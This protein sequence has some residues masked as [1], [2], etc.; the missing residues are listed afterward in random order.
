[1]LDTWFSSAL[2]PFATL[3]WPDDTPRLR[4]F[5]PGPRAVHGARH[6]QPLGRAHD[7][8][9]ASRSPGTEPFQDVVI[10]PT[11]LA[12][13]GRRMS[14]S[15][16]TGVDPLDLIARH[17]ADA[18][19][20]GLLKMSSTQDVRFAEGTIEEG[21]GLCNKLWNAARLILLNVDPEAEPA[22][23]RAEPVDA[24][25]LGRLADAD[26]RGDR[27]ARRATTSPRRSRRSTASSGTT[28]A[29]GTS[30]PPRRASTATTRRRG[31]TSRRRCCYVLARDAAARASRAAARDR[32]HLGGARRATACW[33]AP[34]GPTPA[35]AQRDADAERAVEAGLRL[36]RQAAPAARRD[37]S[38][39]RARRST[40]A[41]LAAAAA[42]PRSSSRSGASTHGA[43][44]AAASGALVDAITVGDAP[45]T[46]LAPGGAE[47]AAAALRAASSRSAEAEVERAR[48]KLAD[49]RFVERAPAHLVEAERDKA[50]ALRARGGRAA[51]APR[52][53]RRVTAHGYLE[54]LAAFGMKL[55]LERITRAARRSSSDPQE[56]LDAIHVVGTNGKSSTVRFAAAALTASGLRTGAYL[57]PHVIGWDERVQIDGRPIG[58]GA[59]AVAL[60]RVQEAAR[61]V[62][63]EHGEGPTQFEALTAAAFLV[64][65]EA[66]VEA[67]VVE[68]GLGG[69]HDAT[70]V[71]N[72][73]VVGLTNVGLDHQRVLGDTREEILAEKLAVLEPRRR[74][75]RR[76]RRRRALRARGRA[77]R[78]GGRELRAHRARARGRRCRCPAA[79]LRD[80]AA[81]A[82]RLAELLLAPR[83]LDRARRERRARRGRAARA[84]SS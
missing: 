34:P 59:L 49:A 40:L 62:E 50:G 80:D 42:S 75:L 73:R 25:V 69:R 24:W 14:K 35:A 64:L 27:R 18:T 13:D 60:D 47:D 56:R 72:A 15:L 82:L 17:G 36:R 78:G 23:S 53:P 1:M 8:D 48:R 33:R 20:Y 22:P 4:A 58:A 52:R 76:R 30:R 41:G 70:R 65:A 26:G 3:G 61:A 28:S 31:A 39:R 44:G 68:A 16:G 5:Y 12:T 43:D 54:S 46:V 19:R 84:A 45:V 55:G 11:V 77:R 21:R 66:G 51:R 38:C 67:C 7:H 57:S 9:W 32:A 10:H 71:V 79:Y 37:A 74:A 29:T 81:L 2:W 83:A 6:H 63:R